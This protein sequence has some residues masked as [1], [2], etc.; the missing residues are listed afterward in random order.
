VRIDGIDVRDLTP[1]DL[2]RQIG[3]VPQES[4][5]FSATLAENI[6][7]GSPSATRA[8]VEEAANLAGL[9]EDIAGF[10][11]GLETVVGERGILLSGGQKQRV[12]IARAIIRK[13]PML[14]F[15]DALSSVDSLT[16]QRILDHLGRVMAGRTTIL[17]SHRMS[18]V[19]RADSVIVLSD[20]DVIEC[21]SHE[22]LIADRGCY[23]EFWQDHL[24]E[25]ELETT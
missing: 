9:A 4:F 11:L 18:T 16:E 25:E 3:F 24:F 10:P 14:V 5:L 23:W 1:H 15:D 13:A 17:I 7:F 8:E 22:R 6:G 19:R 21:G 12:A 2:R 20:G